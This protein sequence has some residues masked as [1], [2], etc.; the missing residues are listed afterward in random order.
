[1]KPNLAGL[2]SK[3]RIMRETAIAE[4]FRF[5]Y[6][7]NTSVFIFWSLQNGSGNTT[8]NP[9][10]G[11]VCESVVSSQSSNTKVE[12]T[13]GSIVLA[14]AGVDKILLWWLLVLILNHL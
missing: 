11:L 3:R 13:G 4:G 12:D 1:M 8:T 7:F 6:R 2:L 14:G 9:N 5:G 10:I